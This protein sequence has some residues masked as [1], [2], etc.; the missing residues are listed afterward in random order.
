MFRSVRC[1]PT[2]VVLLFVA[3]CGGSKNGANDLSSDASD[4]AVVGGDDGGADLAGIAADDMGSGDLAT[5][6][7]LS[8][9]A[10]VTLM[11]TNAEPDAI[12]S[13]DFTGD[14]KADLLVQSW[15]GIVNSGGGALDVLISN[16]D[17]TFAYNASLM[18]TS[19]TMTPFTVGRYDSD[20]KA[21]L[22][23]FYATCTK[24]PKTGV[25]TC[26]PYLVVGLSNGDGTFST[27]S[28]PPAPTSMSS[29]QTADLNGDG[30]VDFVSDSTDAANAKNGFT[31]YLNNGTANALTKTDYLSPTYPAQTSDV[32]VADLNAD[33]RPDIFY[34][35]QNAVVIVMNN[36]NGT[37]AT[38]TSLTT[39]SAANKIA[40]AD[41]FNGDHRPDLVIG[42]DT[43]TFTVICRLPREASRS[44]MTTRLG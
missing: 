13:G 21:D 3:G 44:R 11:T 37:F 8:F 5:G 22:A 30:V 20:A 16:G 19:G 9:A 33:G 43:Q 41:D 23:Q 1:W 42:H 7:T 40:F 36:G 35:A 4:M 18:M 29:L 38:P 26:T 10:P 6:K 28:S 32:V 39:S 24:N 27:T 2:I 12:R 14:G 34:G 25:T 31:V 15:S 17:G